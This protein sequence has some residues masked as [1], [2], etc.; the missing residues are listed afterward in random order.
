MGRGCFLDKCTVNIIHNHS[1]VA[2]CRSSENTITISM[3]KKKQ[4]E[5]N[6][7]IL[8]SFL[9]TVWPENLTENEILH[10]GSWTN[11]PAN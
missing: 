11:K 5:K 2:I 1:V 3:E 7:S 10:I 9:V 8:L 4:I 6:E